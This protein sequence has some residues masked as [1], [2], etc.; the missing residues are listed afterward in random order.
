MPFTVSGQAEVGQGGRES[1]FNARK[2]E[3]SF[4]ISNQRQ[5]CTNLILCPTKSIY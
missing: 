3:L 1:R 4:K 5:F 2:L